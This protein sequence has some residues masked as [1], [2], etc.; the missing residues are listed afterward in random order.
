M[1][2][3]NQRLIHPSNKHKHLTNNHSDDFVFVPQF[4]HNYPQQ[5]NIS[6]QALLLTDS[7]TNM[8]SDD[9]LLS[10]GV[11]DGGQ[12][13]LND[14]PLQPVRPLLSSPVTIN[15]F[16]NVR[17]TYVTPLEITN[18]VAREPSGTVNEVPIVTNMTDDMERQVPKIEEGVL[19]ADSVTSSKHQPIDKPV[20]K[21]V[22]MAVKPAIKKCDL[23]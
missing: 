3:Q 13:S 17:T 22:D 5:S 16:K 14:D 7:L 19:I 4:R 11:D 6:N 15:F 20:D 10:T 23:S 18:L 9:R 2:S 21:P 12:L 1:R 8:V